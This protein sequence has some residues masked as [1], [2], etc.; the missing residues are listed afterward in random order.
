[1][2]YEEL[3]SDFAQRTKANLDLVEMH[4]ARGAPHTAFEVTQLVNSMLG[5][6]VF[7]Q[8]RW[9]DRIP[10]TPLNQLIANG[11]PSITVY[12]SVPDDDLRGLSRYLRNAIS[13][14]NVEFLSDG[15]GDIGGL[16]IWNTPPRKVEP[17]WKAQ[18][19]IQ[20]LRFI[21]LRFIDMLSDHQ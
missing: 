1:M 20:A 17:D 15:F 3:V 4:A 18:L 6:L 11:W 8:Q 9:F 21:A 5:L 7:P 13:H 12:G 10:R 16:R 14:C 19:S 2:N